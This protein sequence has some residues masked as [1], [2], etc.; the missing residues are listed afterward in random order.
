MVHMAAVRLGKI[1]QPSSVTGAMRTP[2]ASRTATD[3]GDAPLAL[4]RL[5]LQGLIV[6]CALPE[7]M[8]VWGLE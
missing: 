8:I 5:V 4:W 1:A 3:R 2:V 7:G 6:V